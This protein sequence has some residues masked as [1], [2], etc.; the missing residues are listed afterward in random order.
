MQQADLSTVS[1]KL[2]LLVQQSETFP[3]LEKL[4]GAAIHD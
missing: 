4:V 1:E 2:I 3:W